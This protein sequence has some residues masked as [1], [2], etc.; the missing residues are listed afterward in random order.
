MA[1]RSSGRRVADRGGRVARATHFQNTH[2]AGFARVFQY[3]APLVAERRA[4]WLPHELRAVE[5]VREVRGI[6]VLELQVEVNRSVRAQGKPIR[7]I[8]RGLQHIVFS[9]LRS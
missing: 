1:Q 6:G 2:L 3:Y 8:G 4:L 5:A 7:K 9:R